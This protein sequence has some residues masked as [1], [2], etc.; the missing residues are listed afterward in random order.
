M[1]LAAS[2]ARE[3]RVGWTL[4]GAAA[5]LLAV[6]IGGGVSPA[7]IA[8]VGLLSLVLAMTWREAVRWHS[9]LALI[10]IVILFIP[11]RRYQMPGHLPFELEPYR[12]LVGLVALGWLMALLVQ[13]GVRLRTSGLE[14]PLAA[15]AGAAVASAIA[16][17]ERVGAVSSYSVKAL[18]YLA[19]FF[20]I[21]FA[22]VSVVQHTVP[23]IRW[24][25]AGG[26]VIAI[27]ALIES[28]ANYNI[29]DHVSTVLPFLTLT[30]AGTVPARGARL[31][32]LASSQH[33]IAL[34]AMFVMLVPLAAALAVTSKQ[35]RWWVAAALLG[36]GALATV[37]RT[38]VLMFV[39]IAIMF[40]WL[41]PQTTR[42]LWPALIPLLLVAHFAVPGTIGSLAGSFFPSGGIVA[43]QQ[44]ANVGS[45]RLA[46]LGPSLGEV[47]PRPVFGEGF[48]TRIVDGPDKNAIIVDD[49][50]LT[51]LLE[52]GVVGILALAWL[53]VHAIK[54]LTRA[55][56]HDETSRGWFLVAIASALAAYMAGMFTYDSFSFVQ[57]TF[58]FFILLALGSVL[59]QQQPGSEP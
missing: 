46:S 17:P 19:S 4:A 12:I 48:G 50:W 11:I 27:L 9:L 2:S 26:A 44:N 54:R 30:D 15:V 51:S 56:R 43:Q 33:P 28:R 21:F 41:R 20:L 24:L 16:N 14:A 1:R 6:T 45:G 23:I 38:S 25:V 10:V 31:R 57:V 49:Q 58:V 8:V 34:G 55:A 37:S 59:L 5:G 39:V 29:F 40:A 13:P 7:P 42:P 52:T 36:L 53:F 35:R 3:A 32:V 22:I 47:K 18:M